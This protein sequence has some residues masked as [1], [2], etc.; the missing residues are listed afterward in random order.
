MSKNSVT[1][2]LITTL[3]LLT[4][5]C[6][7]GTL[8]VHAAPKAVS[9]NNNS[10]K[11]TM[12]ATQRKQLK[13]KLSGKYKKSDVVYSSSNKK[14]ATVN[15]KGVVK[16]LKKGNITVYAQIK[17]TSKKAK[18]K[19]KVF[20]NVKSIKVVG[21]KKHYY[22]GEQYQ[23]NYKTTPK[24]TLEEI[25]WNSSNDDVA[26]IS[27]DGL[28][29]IKEKGK[30]K[31][32]VY[33]KE[34][35]VKKTYKIKTEEAPQI[36]FKNGN[37]ATV[38]YG[39]NYQIVLQYTNHDTE[40]IQYKSEDQS[41]A[42]VDANG[43]VTTKRPGEVY[44]TATPSKKKETLRMLLVVEYKTGFFEN[45]LLYDNIDTSGCNKLMIVAHPDDET[46]WGGAHLKSGN[47]FVVC[48][49]NH[50]TDVRKN[51]FKSVMEKAGIKGIILD[52][53]DLVRDAN[54]K[55]VKYDWDSVKDGVAADV[56]K[57]IKSKNWDL[58]ATHSPAG[59]TGHIHHKNTDQAVT[60]ACISTGN[61]DKLWYF[62]K[63]YWKIPS[64]L[65]RITDEELTF[66][67]SLVDLY[68]NETKPI[69]TY[70][71]Q[72]IPYENWVKATD[73]VAAK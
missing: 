13:V 61:Y 39:N 66:K 1:K 24:K 4:C 60:N 30:V 40:K 20:K 16:A 68:K 56:T 46:L 49:T 8:S 9:F 47:W 6:G 48:L 36:S 43:L 23:L 34:T 33:S 45:S 35:K 28:L 53:P 55:W 54:K 65:K 42:T 11:I 7:I 27:E 18:C 32:T 72:M 21:R 5:L 70:W 17:G 38:K 12:F 15:K 62:G 73:Y 41:I 51:E 63:C 29:T 69:N 64:G 14:V 37:K 2:K 19:V 59:E 31:I 22:I 50:F 3:A 58:I 10:K 67:Q 57:L 26:T 44:I 71:A 25:T 52:Y